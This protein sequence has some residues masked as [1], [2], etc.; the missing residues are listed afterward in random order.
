MQKQP[1]YKQ[2]NHPVQL[3]SPGDMFGSQ[4]CQPDSDIEFLH[5]HDHMEIGYCHRGQGIF[6]IE[7]EVL[8]YRQGDVIIIP[9][10]TPHLAQ[11][12]LGTSSDWTFCYLSL[13]AMLAPLMPLPPAL[14]SA[15]APWRLLRGNTHQGI[16]QLTALL[17]HSVL[18]AHET[19][20]LTLQGLV[21]ALFS[22][23][24][25]PD[26]RNARDPAGHQ[27][28][29]QIAPAINYLGTH[30]T[31]A[32]CTETLAHICFLSPGHFRRL[33]KKK[34]GIRPREYIFKLR[35]EMAKDLLLLNEDPI[36]RIAEAVGFTTLSSF[37][38]QFNT[39]TGTSPSTWRHQHSAMPN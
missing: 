4:Y 36:T 18:S 8:R 1:S 7:N 30:F 31:Q 3:P 26:A 39:L 38:R 23:L 11:S 20:P 5:I 33:F 13:D 29:S 35:I 17:C 9:P 24:S 10:G 37:N 27:N 6:I 14:L 34:M 2:I 19:R 25:T 32:L 22:M 12:T 21:L 16:S 28:L 15:A